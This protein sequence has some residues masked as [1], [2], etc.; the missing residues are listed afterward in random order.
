LI[1][2]PLSARK[3]KDAPYDGAKGVN[4]SL[5][6]SVAA[7][8]RIIFTLGIDFFSECFAALRLTNPAKLLTKDEARRL[9]ANIVNRSFRVVSH[10]PRRSGPRHAVVLRIG[11][12]RAAAIPAHGGQALLKR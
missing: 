5:Q 11:S 1:S 7:G 10:A 6:K 4:K 2:G 9:A 8:K 12:T 3:R